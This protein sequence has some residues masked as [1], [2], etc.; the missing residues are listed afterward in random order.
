MSLSGKTV[1]RV[2]QVVANEFAVIVE[3]K[4]GEATDGKIRETRDQRVILGGT[5]SFWL[6]GG[7]KKE[8]K[9]AI[10]KEDASAPEIASGISPMATR[11]RMGSIF[12]PPT[13]SG[14]TV[15]GKFDTV[16]FSSATKLSTGYSP[17]DQDTGKLLAALAQGE[18]V[19]PFE[20]TVSAIEVRPGQWLTSG[21]EVLSSG[22]YGLTQPSLRAIAVST[23][24]NRPEI[25]R[26][27][28]GLA[29]FLNQPKWSEPTETDLRSEEQIFQSVEQWLTR[30]KAA[31]SLPGSSDMLAPADILR[32]LTDRAVTED[33]KADLLTL[34]Q[35][36]SKRSELIDILPAILARDPAYL[37]RVAEFENLE[38]ARL[39]AN[40]EVELRKEAE[41]ERSRLAG[42]RSQIADA[43]ARLAMYS[44]R[45]ILLKNETTVHEETL[46]AKIESTAKDLGIDF[47]REAALIRDEV[48]RIRE[49]LA[50]ITTTPPVASATAEV[51]QAKTPLIN[52]DVPHASEEQ[53]QN[54]LRDLAA[55]TGLSI[56][57]AAAVVASAIDV[58][59]VLIGANASSAVIDIAMTLGG[60][61]TAIVFCDPTKVSFG[62]F[63]NDDQSGLR[64][65]IERARERPELL[66][67]TALCNITSCPCEY[68]LPQIVELRRKGRLPKN[69]AFVGS[70]GVD[71]NRV[72]IPAS[73]LQYLFPIL[74][75]NKGRREPIKFNGFW[76]VLAA[77]SSER[78]Q[79]AV[80]ILVQRGMEGATLQNAARTL[81]RIPAWLSLADIADILLRQAQWLAASAAG[82]D[83]EY[84]KYFQE[85]EI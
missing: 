22:R 70:A 3:V 23:L 64:T 6:V 21:F 58:M 38:K 57:Q 66:A 37:K 60:N 5:G 50:Q 82:E 9:L 42:V 20:T 78:F 41:T 61:D 49:E 7:E 15:R 45:E 10:Q 72:S 51:S 85:I 71:G 34:A 18:L 76:P 69:L 48:A 62:D 54:T 77:P 11:I 24:E 29:V 16:S 43:E 47:R 67:W 81:S 32:L 52:L 2:R 28:Q 65:T 40:L 74:P 4:A 33:E 84:K 44:H 56:P 1:Y 8:Q 59:P 12:D 27:P 63:L 80:D 19:I 30:S 68:W 46:R 79:E 83:H 75:A 26:L 14:E 39:R 25:I 36:L 53:R 17:G 13:M 55:A 31:L 35:Y 73:A